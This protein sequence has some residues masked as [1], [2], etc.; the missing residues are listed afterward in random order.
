MDDLLGGRLND[1]LK[2]YAGRHAFGIADRPDLP[3]AV[4][5]A[6][7]EDIEPLMVDYLDTYL[8]H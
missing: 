5:E 4:L 8:L 3:K 1:A 7:G 2:H 6:T